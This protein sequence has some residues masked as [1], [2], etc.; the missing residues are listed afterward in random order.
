MDKVVTLCSEL[1]KLVSPVVCSSSPEGFLPDSTEA[2]DKEGAGLAVPLEPAASKTGTAQ[3]LLLC[4]WHVMKEIALLLGYLVGCAPV[5]SGIH[6]DGVLT[7]TQVDTYVHT[8]MH[9]CV[10]IC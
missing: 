6:G 10:I 9:E 8:F 2:R 5:I 7:H 4:C 3:S 1:A